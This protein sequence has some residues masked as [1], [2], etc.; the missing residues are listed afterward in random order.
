MIQLFLKPFRS[1][2]VAKN[3]YLFASFLK[4]PDS[5]HIKPKVMKEEKKMFKIIVLEDSEFFNNLLTKQLEQYTSMLAIERNCSFNIQSYT[6]AADCLRN[7]KNDTDIAFVD[8]YLGNGTTGFDVLKKIRQ[9]CWDCKVIIISQSR[10]L[11]TKAISVTE[12]VMDFIF[13]DINALPKSCFIVEDIV[14]SRISPHQN[15]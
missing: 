14:D 11:K 6:S 12:G 4:N 15:N 1:K 8:F 3:K 7:L 2:T 10:N 9:R 13:K 5:S